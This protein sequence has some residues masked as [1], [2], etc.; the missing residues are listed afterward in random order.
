M[1]L[2]AITPAFG[3][4]DK[5]LDI[6]FITLLESTLI[7][8]PSP[9]AEQPE[10]HLSHSGE[11]TQES[12]GSLSP[13]PAV[14]TDCWMAWGCAEGPVGTPAGRVRAWKASCQ[15]PSEAVV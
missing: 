15:K 12:Q 8:S 7:P 1:A 9:I 13:S 11:E 5:I 14:Q 10:V 6:F 3:E 4:L 2:N